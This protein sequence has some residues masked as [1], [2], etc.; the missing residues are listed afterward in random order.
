MITWNN[1]D[2]VSAYQELQKKAPVNLTEAMAGG[3]A[4]ARETH[5]PKNLRLFTTAR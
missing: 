1:L 4:A 3:N 2:T 5:F